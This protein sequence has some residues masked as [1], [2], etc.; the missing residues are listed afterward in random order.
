MFR[1]DKLWIIRS[2]NISCPVMKKIFAIICFGVS[3][4][5]Y[6]QESKFAEVNGTSI[7]YVAYG[8]GEPVLLLHNFTASHKMWI[9]WLA[10]LPKE[11]RYIIPDLRGHGYSEIPSSQFRHD[12]SA[13]DMFGLMDA[14]GI[15]KFRAIGTSSGGMTLLHMTTM[16]TSRV[17]SMILVGATPYFPV[18]SRTNAQ[19]AT[20]ETINSGWKSEIL[21]YQPNGEKQARAV[22]KLFRELSSYDDMNFTPPYL[23]R[24]KCPTLIIHGD[25]DNHFSLEIPT[26]LYKSIPNSYLWVIPNGGHLPFVHNKEDSIWSSVFINVM[27][28]FFDG[29]RLK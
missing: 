24:I 28:E 12:D 10:D 29:K 8:Q 5:A 2:N 19:N 26:I 21:R 11:Y 13:Q 1:S 25:R 23:S 20:F 16:D 3:I 18:S 9:P 6:S 17:E 7:H 4:M 15:K 22:L 14:L 27:T